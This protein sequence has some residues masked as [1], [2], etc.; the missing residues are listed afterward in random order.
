MAVVIDIHG[1]SALNPGT[2]DEWYFKDYAY[3]GAKLFA[4]GAALSAA[5]AA[6]GVM[7]VPTAAVVG[8]GCVCGSLI[9]WAAS[10]AVFNYAD[11]R[12]LVSMRETALRRPLIES[13]KTH[14]WDNMIRYEILT[15][16]EAKAKFLVDTEHL[17]MKTITDS[18]GW[19][20][21]S[22][23]QLWTYDQA[24][25]KYNQS[26]KNMSQKDYANYFS[27]SDLDWLVTYK[28]LTPSERQNWIYFKSSLLSF[29]QM[30][31]Q[32]GW[33]RIMQGGVVHPNQLKWA[34]TQETRLL[35]GVKFIERYSLRDIARFEDANLI[36]SQLRAMLVGL[37]DH[38]KTKLSE[39]TRLIERLERVFDAE[40]AGLNLERDDALAQ[41]ESEKSEALLALEKEQN[42]FP[43][44]A[45]AAEVQLINEGYES[46][47][48]SIEK[49][50]S[51]ELEKIEARLDLEMAPLDEQVTELKAEVNFNYA[52]LQW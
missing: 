11:P 31:N 6:T 43:L 22:K 10:E 5:A 20:E 21:I 23:R 17:D 2:V 46:H 35:T 39:L 1:K 48:T 47:K 16:S 52:S 45:Y 19:N 27:Y 49:R 18:F 7:A 28:I 14:G 50:Y 41:I 3:A 26:V 15:Y 25:F 12:D 13:I 51:V 33:D 42:N 34:F 40:I 38:Y 36:S 44:N 4:L 29:S 24:L 37:V 9:S 32:F 30:L 8:T